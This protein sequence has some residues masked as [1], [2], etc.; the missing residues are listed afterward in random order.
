MAR[1]TMSAAPNLQTIG[2]SA[3]AVPTR[4]GE[5][6]MV[7]VRGRAASIHT[8]IRLG[9]AWELIEARSALLDVCVA[10]LLSLFA[11]VIKECRVSGE[12]LDSGESVGVGVERGL[13]EADRERTL[14]EDPP[15]PRDGLCLE[16]VEGHDLVYKAHRERLLG[17]V[18]IAE[19][20]DLAGFL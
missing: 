12:L 4:T 6:A 19:I 2:S 1:A 18:L 14:L 11:H 8:F 15:G 13:Q 5:I 17:A 9:P 7:R 20:P 3:D 10:P 16:P